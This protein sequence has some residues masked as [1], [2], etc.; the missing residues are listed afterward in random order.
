VGHSRFQ[1]SSVV[2]GVVGAIVSATGK[3]EVED[4]ITVLRPALFFAPGLNPRR[5]GV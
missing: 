2:E 5:V 4:V 3:A 1:D